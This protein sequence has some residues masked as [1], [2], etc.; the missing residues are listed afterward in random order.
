M[1]VA[2]FSP[3]LCSFSVVRLFLCCLCETENYMQHTHVDYV[4]ITW[5][6]YSRTTYEYNPPYTRMCTFLTKKKIN[7]TFVHS[8]FFLFSFNFFPFF[9][10]S[11]WF[12]CLLRSILLLLLSMYFTFNSEQL[13]KIIASHQI[14][15]KLLLWRPCLWY[16]QIHFWGVLAI[17]F[18]CFTR[19]QLQV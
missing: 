15:L 2:D 1:W 7:T 16:S 5:H 3:K 14:L 8:F 10:A 13:M 4:Y 17:D 19:L 12:C 11:V 6:K 18:V 9:A